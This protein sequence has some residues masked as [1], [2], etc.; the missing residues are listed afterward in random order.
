VSGTI[1]VAGGAG[2]VGSHTVAGLVAAGRR[3]V[4]LDDLSTG[5]REVLRGVPLVVGSVD[6]PDLVTRTCAAHGVD[7]VLH[8]AGRI[9]VAESVRDPALY[10]RANVTATGVLAAAVARAGVKRF[11]FSSSA[12]VYG[13]P[14]RV[15]IPED[16]PQRPTSPYGESKARAE[17]VLAAS[18]LAVAALRYFNAAGAEP[19]LSL[20]E[21][22]DPETHLVP[23]ALAAARHGTPLSV[24]G[25]DYPTPDGTCVRDYIHV[26]DLARA[27]LAALERLEAGRGGGAW[28]LG[29]GA[30]CSVRE[31]VGAVERATGRRVTVHAAPRRV[32]DPAVLVADPSRAARDLGW[33]A[34]DRSRLDA[35]VADAW[36]FVGLEG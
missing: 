5:H 23:L 16:H 25:E 17:R 30:G 33:R 26:V 24:F 18:G 36:A 29:T 21:R 14:E 15:P 3:V 1:L 10:E 12:A 6:D 4:V 9:S 2:Y 32:G 13:N 19:R 28:N 20:G 34:S 7:A 8:F 11:V 27:H 22:H 31:V 35:I